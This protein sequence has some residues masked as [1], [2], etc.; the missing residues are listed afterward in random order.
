MY[1]DL[2]SYENYFCL[3]ATKLIMLKLVKTIS[4]L[5]MHLCVMTLV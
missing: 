5:K 3:I 1:Y 2:I 4:L